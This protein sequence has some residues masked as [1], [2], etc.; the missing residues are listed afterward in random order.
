VQDLPG[1]CYYDWQGSLPHEADG[2]DEER[3]RGALLKV[4]QPLNSGPFLWGRERASAAIRQDQYTLLS[5]T[6]LK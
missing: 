3:G 2:G 5:L 4:R 6:W 1:D